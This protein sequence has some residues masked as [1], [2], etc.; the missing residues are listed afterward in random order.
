MGK[1]KMLFVSGSLG[2]GHVARDLAIANE[3]RAINKDVEIIWLADPPASDYIRMTGET[4]LP[5]LD[6]ISRNTNDIV[7]SHAND[8]ELML[9]PYFMDWYQTFP[10]RV[11]IINAAA[12]REKV[13][14]ILGDET[15]DLYCTYASKKNLKIK[16]FLLILDFIGAY[17]DATETKWPMKMRMAFYMFQRWT[18]T[19]MKSSYGK[20]GTIFV[21]ET[22][23][24]PADKLA[25][26]MPNRRE[27]VRRYGNSVGYILN[28]D[29]A[30]VGSKEEMRKRLGYGP[31]P[32]VLVTIGGTAAGAPLL[33]K[34]VA[35]YSFMKKSVPELNMV[36]VNGPRVPLDYVQ[37]SNGVKVLGMVP[38]LYQHMV[39]SDLVICSGGGTTTTEL[40]ALNKPFL[41][42]P[43]K[44]HFEQNID[45]AYHLQRDKIGVKMAYDE[46]SPEL[47]ASK[48][49][50]NLG[51][52]VN[53][54]KVRTDG[55]TR[56]AAHTDMVLKR[57]ERGEIK[58]AG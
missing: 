51:R 44:K 25:I 57:I 46:T 30:T 55:A 8:Y 27:I 2:L 6:K 26:P 42:F 35:A 29:P 34:A 9:N 40:Q 13:D 54:T 7:D 19:H 50:E 14:L 52:Q 41:Y 17:K 38:N 37:P 16:P 49:L 53:Y 15:Y 47:L 33:K 31:E 43:L 21:G 10:E 56:A 11:G 3:L 28:F 23:D 32:L 20:E 45:V 18:Y 24:V 1:Q 39:A 58:V 4:V 12:V 5:D 22:D 36:L 48:A